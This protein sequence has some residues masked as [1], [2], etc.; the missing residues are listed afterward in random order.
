MMIRPVIALAALLAAALPAIAAE[1]HAHRAA[2]ACDQLT[3][4]CAAAVTAATAADG[5]L[6]LV[7]SAAGRVAVT[8]SGDGGASFTPPVAVSGQ[9]ATID[10]NGEAR[11]KLFA[12]RDGRL[13]VTW[14]ARQDKGYVGTVWLARSTDNGGHWSAPQRLT[15]DTASQR[16][17]I[18]GMTADGRLAAVWIDKRGGAAAKRAGKAYAGAG[19]VAAWSDDGGASFGP[20]QVLADHSCECCRLGL[21]ALSDGGLALVWRHVFDGGVRDHAAAILRPEGLGPIRRV[22]DDQ[23]KVDGCPHHGP[24][25]TVDGDG[26]WQAAWF[27]DGAKRQGLFH[28]VSR[29]GGRTFSAPRPLGN[30]DNQPSHPAL[31]AEGARVWL[32]WKEFDGTRTTIQAQMSA[33]GG[34]TWSPPRAIAATA[35]AS[36][37][38][39]LIAVGG[40]PR[41]SWLTRAEGWRLLPVEDVP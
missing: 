41:L 39:Q 16:F 29:D 31:L 15:A 11:P 14:T 40:Q 10:D 34:A 24:A 4:A 23:W 37:H 6:W 3:P 27:T 17:E 9:P 35:D 2:Q 33:D 19:L 1:H 25:L 30:A 26:H 28:A 13:L 38:P 21:S 22:A 5:G 12:G 18:V 20:E 36:D 8:R 32:A 7:F